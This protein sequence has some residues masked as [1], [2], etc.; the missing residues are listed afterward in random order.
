MGIP[1]AVISRSDPTT[2][3]R[4]PRRLILLLD[5][6]NSESSFDDVLPLS[7]SICKGTVYV[8]FGTTG[9]PWSSRATAIGTG[10]SRVNDRGD[11]PVRGLTPG[12]SWPR[13]TRRGAGGALQGVRLRPG[14]GLGATKEQGEHGLAA[15]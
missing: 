10:S 3:D 13:P 5:C 1:G 11:P 6:Q 9:R 2:A 12:L 7:V 14:R 4:M 8:T 15:S